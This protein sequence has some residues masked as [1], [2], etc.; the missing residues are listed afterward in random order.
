MARPQRAAAGVAVLLIAALG[1]PV[2]VFGSPASLAWTNASGPVAGYVVHADVDGAGFVFRGLALTNAFAVD[3][4]AGESWVVRVAAFDAVGNMGPWSASSSPIVFPATGSGGGG[5]GGLGAGFVISFPPVT[6]S[7]GVSVWKNGETGAV[8]FGIPS[9]AGFVAV[10]ADPGLRPRA[11]GDFDGDGRD[12]LLL[13]DAGTGAVE[14]WLLDGARVTSK[15]SAPKG[16]I[17]AWEPV[18]ALDADADGEVD[19]LWW[20]R[21]NGATELWYMQG[22]TRVDIGSLPAAVKGDAGSFVGAGDFDGDG[23]DDVAWHDDA[24]GDVTVWPLPGLITVPWRLGTAR[25]V[26]PAGIGDLDG[27]GTTDL[28]WHDRSGGG[29]AAWLVHEDIEEVEIFQGVGPEWRVGGVSNA[30]GGDVELL[31]RNEATHIVYR[32][33]L[34]ALAPASVPSVVTLPD[35]NWERM[36][37]FR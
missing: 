35:S 20:N 11:S 23:Y 34:Q 30:R 36:S 9:D 6:P 26:V 28:V 22:T 10:P 5:G 12:D 17:G 7:G 27:D 24:S 37:D 25:G 31:W 16:R 8:G 1:V 32:W 3:G 19:V 13:H 21:A 2:A 14:I 29:V 15:V 4:Q 33:T 18:A